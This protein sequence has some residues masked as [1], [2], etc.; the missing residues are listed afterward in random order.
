M[1]A[2]IPPHVVA[3]MVAV[4][5]AVFVVSTM[6]LRY[7]W[8]EYGRGDGTLPRIEKRYMMGGVFLLLV[9]LASAIV[10]SI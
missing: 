6:I 8:R 7:H 2:W 5:I 10:Y 9:M 3:I 1:S 4:V